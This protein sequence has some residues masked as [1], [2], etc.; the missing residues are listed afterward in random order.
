MREKVG[1]KHEIYMICCSNKR[2]NRNQFSRHH[3]FSRMNSD[4]TDSEEKVA[5]A[6]RKELFCQLLAQ[7]LLEAA[8]QW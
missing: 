8:E 4:A 3:I 1:F 6:A 7:E 5:S 2:K